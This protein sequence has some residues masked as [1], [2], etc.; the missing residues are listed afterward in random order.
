MK[1]MSILLNSYLGPMSSLKN[2]VP[3][4]ILSFKAVNYFLDLTRLTPTPN[5]PKLSKVITGARLGSGTKKLSG[6]V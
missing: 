2:I 1:E 5:K 3:S 4:W 6:I